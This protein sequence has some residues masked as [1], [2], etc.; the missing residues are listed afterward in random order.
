[1]EKKLE[2]S[3]HATDLRGLCLIHDNA[4]AHTYVQTG[5]GFPVNRKCGK[6]PQSAQFTRL[7]SM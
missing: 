1:M 5:S 3:R 4:G 7:E 2:K 6:A